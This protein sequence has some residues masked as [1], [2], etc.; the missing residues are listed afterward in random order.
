ML[1]R[2]CPRHECWAT[3]Y[4]RGE[5]WWKL[6]ALFGFV[7]GS[8]CHYCLVFAR[9]ELPKHMG[10]TPSTPKPLNPEPLAGL[11]SSKKYRTAE[12]PTSRSL[13][14]AQRL[15]V[16]VGTSCCGREV[17]TLAP[18]PLALNPTAPNQTRSDEP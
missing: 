12:G 10:C 13:T 17:Y 8:A 9:C 3:G 18:S 2:F 4:A 15:Q 1:T 5:I 16:Q 6:G 14:R 7:V 11:Q